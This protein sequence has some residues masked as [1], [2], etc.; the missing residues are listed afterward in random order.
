MSTTV[1]I[2]QLKMNKTTIRDDPGNEN[3]DK[4]SELIEAIANE[5]KNLFLNLPDDIMFILLQFCDKE[6]I[7]ETRELHS[8]WI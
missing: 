3:R 8:D 4:N 7:T 6:D 5:T 1:Y 2:D